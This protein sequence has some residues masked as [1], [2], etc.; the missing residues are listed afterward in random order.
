MPSPPGPSRISITGGSLQYWQR[1]RFMNKIPRATRSRWLPMKD[2]ALRFL[3]QALGASTAVMHNGQEVRD[4][5]IHC[6][7]TPVKLTII[8]PPPTITPWRLLVSSEYSS[9]TAE[10]GPSR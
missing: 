7:V 3:M 6:T 8:K 1:N 10:P 4:A 5:T 2:R 9:T